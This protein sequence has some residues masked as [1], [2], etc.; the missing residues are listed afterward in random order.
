MAED[1]SPTAD[2]SADAEAPVESGGTDISVGPVGSDYVKVGADASGEYRWHRYAANNRNVS[3]SEEG[4]V[5]LAYAIEMAH[6]LN[7]DVE[8]RVISADGSES[9]A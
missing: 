5:D 7:P 8:V 9:V 6:R 4:Y 2:P 3:G 1:T